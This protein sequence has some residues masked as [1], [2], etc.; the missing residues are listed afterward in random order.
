MYIYIALQNV[1]TQDVCKT[2]NFYV[3]KKLL[4]SE[5]TIR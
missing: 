5:N 2:Y 4:V 3:Q 1:T